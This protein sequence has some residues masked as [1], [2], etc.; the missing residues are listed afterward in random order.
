MT[1]GF[2]LEFIFLSLVALLR[3]FPSGLDCDLDLKICGL[4][5]GLVTFDLVNILA[6]AVQFI[7]NREKVLHRKKSFPQYK[8]RFPLAERGRGRQN[9]SYILP[10]GCA[11][12]RDD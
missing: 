2:T 7:L 12:C 1:V 5:F 8:R 10:S 6:T 11:L 4:G 9:P 3:P